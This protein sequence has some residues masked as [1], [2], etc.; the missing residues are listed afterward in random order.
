MCDFIKAFD[1]V[2]CNQTQ[3]IA[4]ILVATQPNGWRNQFWSNNCG[5]HVL[6]SYTLVWGQ[7]KFKTWSQLY[8]CMNKMNGDH[9]IFIQFVV[10]RVAICRRLNIVL[11]QIIQFVWLVWNVQLLAYR[12]HFISL[13][14]SNFKWIL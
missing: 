2:H 6:F 7:S 9:T 4:T 5:S 12:F 10:L 1:I 14:Y 8:V 13:Y 11:I 3:L